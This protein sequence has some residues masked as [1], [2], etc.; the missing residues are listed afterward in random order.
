MRAPAPG[1]AEGRGPHMANLI[2]SLKNA[3]ARHDKR[4]AVTGYN[5]T[6]ADS[7]NQLRE[8]DWDALTADAGVFLSRRYLRVLEQAGAQNVQQRYALVYDGETPVA[9]VAAQSVTV[10]GTRMMKGKSSSRASALARK[11]AAL[12]M[13][14]W[15]ER[16]LVCGNCMSWG[17]Y[18]VAFAKGT[19]VAKAWGGVAEALYRIRKSDRL[20]GET[21]F[22]MVKDI[23]AAMAQDAQA[24]RDFSYKRMDTDP[25]MVLNL[26][27]YRTYEDYLQSLT[28]KYRKAA[29]K[30]DKDLTEAGY[31]V[32]TV[33]VSRLDAARLHALYMQV[34]DG[35]P[36]RLV[37]LTDRFFPTMQKVFGAE[38]RCTVAR[39]GDR[40]DGFIT[41]LKNGPDAVGY[42]IGF[43]RAA[44]AKV[45]LYFRLL[46]AAVQDGIALG[47]RNLSL[48]RTALEPK[49]K[50]GA[51]AQPLSIWVRHRFQP[52]NLVVR[53]VLSNVE[54]DEPPERNPFK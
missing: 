4:H 19:N 17:P 18:G 36:V 10:N 38:F 33:D 46:Y 44:N 37:T 54:H 30:L 13:Q 40:V 14:Q 39:Q 28:S 29:Q 5:I 31:T 27:K 51:V 24:L 2:Q 43:D 26:E 45:P 8:Q 11:A 16:L 23:P 48:G 34:H 42:F 47:A 20:L 49:A 7:V 52:L 53:A 35:A 32:E 21:D 41:T 50:L 12:P 15:E 3:K 25:D 9:A 6:L 1:G 22:V